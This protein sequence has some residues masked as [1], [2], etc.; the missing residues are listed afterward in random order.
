MHNCK[1]SLS[2]HSRLYPQNV[3][4]HEDRGVVQDPFKGVMQSAY[5]IGEVLGWELMKNFNR[6][7]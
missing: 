3:F 1:I 4:F 6:N 5:E 7:Y 2:V